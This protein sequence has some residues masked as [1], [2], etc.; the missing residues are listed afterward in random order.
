MV[1]HYELTLPN[2]L[3]ID[4]FLPVKVIPLASEISLHTNYWCLPIS[5]NTLSTFE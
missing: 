3:K 1:F 2:W 4:Q 5:L